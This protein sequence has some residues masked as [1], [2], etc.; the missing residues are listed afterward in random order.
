MMRDVKIV[1]RKKMVVFR[2]TCGVLGCVRVFHF[3][4]FFRKAPFYKFT[5]EI[6]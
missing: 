2:W 6:L 1:L 5:K 4:C 3:L